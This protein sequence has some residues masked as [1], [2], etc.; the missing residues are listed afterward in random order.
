MLN[1]SATGES[2]ARGGNRRDYMY[3]HAERLCCLGS[4]DSRSLVKFDAVS[5]DIDEGS[6]ELYVK[7]PRSN[8]LKTH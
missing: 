6:G 2:S 1:R 5:S 3:D 4:L 8:V 7:N